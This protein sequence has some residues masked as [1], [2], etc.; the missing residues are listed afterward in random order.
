[1]LDSIPNVL[2]V[3]SQWS[4]HSTMIKS[5]PAI[6]DYPNWVQL[7][8]M[9]LG[10]VNTHAGCSPL[11]LFSLIQLSTFLW[12]ALVLPAMGYK[13]QRKEYGPKDAVILK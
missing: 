6:S 8:E 13:V 5:C 11:P 10:P 9:A 4:T 2:H 12:G 1:M 7:P 3:L